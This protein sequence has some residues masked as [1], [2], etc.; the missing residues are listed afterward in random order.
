MPRHSGGIMAT[1][2]VHAPPLVAAILMAS[3]LRVWIPL[4]PLW[5]IT[6]LRA[7][8]FSGF[9]HFPFSIFHFTIPTPLTFP[10]HQRC[11]P[12]DAY[13]NFAA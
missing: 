1:L 11:A 13:A 9:S 6:R 7:G 2:P 10:Q 5:R 8:R 12:T 4:C 3:S